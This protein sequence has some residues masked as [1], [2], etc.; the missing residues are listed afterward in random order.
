MSLKGEP[1]ISMVSAALRKKE[2][3]GELS[4]AEAAVQRHE[5]TKKICDIVKRSVNKEISNDT[6][7]LLMNNLLIE[8]DA[9]PTPPTKSQKRPSKIKNLFSFIALSVAKIIVSILAAIIF[10]FI[11][12]FLSNVPLLYSIILSISD[13]YVDAF[14]SLITIITA[15]TLCWSMALK[16][17]MTKPFIAV[18]VFDGILQTLALVSNFMHNEWLWPNIVSLVVILLFINIARKDST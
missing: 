17:K 6:Y 12:A 7:V 15:Y 13:G 8:Y 1:E 16:F 2:A 11:L 14:I 5:A 10:T 4:S 3:R 9:L 18:C